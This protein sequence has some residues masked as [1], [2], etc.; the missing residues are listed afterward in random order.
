M[1]TFLQ[2]QNEV[3]QTLHGYGLSQPRAT[4]LTASVDASELVFAVTSA[5]DADMG[6]AE[7]EGEL[8]FIESV[9][10]TANTITIAPDGRGFYGTTAAT[11]ASGVRVTIAPSWPRN[12]VKQAINDVIASVYPTIFG[13]A[14]T[15]FT[16]NPSI[17]TY[18]LPVAAERVLSV[19]AD[20]NGPSLEQQVIKRYSFSSTAPTDDWATTNTISIQEGVT[21]G[22]TVTVT[23]LQQPTA[24]SLDADALTTSGLRETAKLAIVYGACAQLLSFMDISRLTVDTAQA[25]EYDEKVQVGMASRIAGQ[26]QI[27]HEM[28]LEKERKRLRATT[29]VNISV[30][31][32]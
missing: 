18:S 14:Q 12:R 6:L 22:R 23:Y 29:P 16:F 9:D 10:R 4:H 24:L 13:V 30:R 28:E 2:L 25:D 27:R 5:A 17:T 15:Q 31:K 7:I 19:T 26:L 32:R 3:L 20:V 1:T 11:H 8:V 21:P